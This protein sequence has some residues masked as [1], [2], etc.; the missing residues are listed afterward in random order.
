MIDRDDLVRCYDDHNW[1]SRLRYHCEHIMRA[2]GENRAAG[3][4]Q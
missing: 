1:R 3:L 4:T 2:P